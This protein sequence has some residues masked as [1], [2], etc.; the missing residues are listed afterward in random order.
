MKKIFLL[1]FSLLPLPLSATDISDFEIKGIKVG[2]NINNVQL[3]CNGQKD[4]FPNGNI[5]APYT[6]Y[7]DVNT[8][9]GK[10]SYI[11]HV[12]SDEKISGLS[13]Q[14]NF[15]NRPNWNALKERV[16]SQYGKPDEQDERY[17]ARDKHLIDKTLCWGG[18]VLTDLDYWIGEAYICGYGSKSNCFGVVYEVRDDRDLLKFI[19]QDYGLTLKSKETSRRMKE[20]MEKNK[21]RRS[22]N[23]DF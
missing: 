5:N 19:A 18:C 12:G 6:I 2:D 8:S 16:I 20:D 15:K 10:E 14:V 13:R 17:F 23:I 21:E 7:C 3:P 22:T 11:F 1:V 9:I 4:H